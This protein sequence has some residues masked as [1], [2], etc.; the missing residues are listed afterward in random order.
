MKKIIRF[1]TDNLLFI[2]VIFLLAFIP[3]YPKLPLLDITNTWVYVRVEDFVVLSTLLIWSVYLFKQKVTLKTPLT[4][5]I[6][7]FWFIGAIST[8]HGVVLI[9]P[10]LANVFPNVA[11]L[12][13]IRHIEYMSLF[14]IAFSAMRDR[15]SLMFVIWTIV[16]TLLVV[17]FYGFGQK[18]LG[19]PAFLTMNEE[20]AKGIPIQLSQLSRVPSTFAGH[21]DLAAYLVLVIPIVVS[22]FFGFKN[23]FAKLILLVSAVLGFGLLFMTV[24]RVSFFV[25]LVALFIVIY[26]QKKRLAVISI[27]VVLVIGLLFISFQPSLLERFGSTVKEVEVLVDAKTGAPVGHVSF[28]PLSYLKDKLIVWEKTRD[29]L[30]FEMILTEKRASSTGVLFNDLP[31]K[32]MPSHVP[33]MQARTVSTGESLP[34]GTGYINLHLSP[35]TRRLGN[36]YYEIESSKN[37][38]TAATVRVIPG[39]FLV[40]KAAAYDLSFTTR[41]QGEWPRAIKAFTNNFFFGSGYGSVSLAVD[42]N[43][44]RMLGETGLLGIGSFFL[45]FVFMGVFIKRILPTVESKL[46]RSFVIGFCAGIVGLFLNGILIDVFEASKIA[47]ILW[48]LIGI[49]VGLLYT[50]KASD[51]DINQETRKALA[52]TFAVLIYIG[53]GTIALFSP[54]LSNFFVGDDFTWLRWAAESKLNLSTITDYFL[55]SD[56]F[57]YRP[58]TKTYF[59]VMYSIFWLNP[60]VYHVV[61]VVLHFLAVVLFY[62]LALKVT[63]DKLVS[64]MS[65]FIF[66]IGSGYLE[67][68][69]WISVT[70]HLFSIVFILLSVLLY[71]AWIDTRRRVFY[72]LSLL[73]IVLGLLFYEMGIVAPL[74]IIAYLLVFK[75]EKIGLRPLLSIFKNLYN[76]LIFTPVVFYLLIRWISQSHWFNGDYSY[77][78]LKL[79]FN[80]VGNLLG[81]ILLTLFGP[82]TLPIYQTLR[83]TARENIFF[84]VPLIL[85]IGT[86]FYFAIRIIKQNL[87]TQERKILLFGILFF[88]ISLIPFLGLG[89]IAPRYSYLA[90]FGLILIFVLVIRKL[91]GYLLIYGRDIAVLGIIVVFSVFSLLHIIQAQQTNNDWNGAGDKT[92]N[93]L[94]SID[95]IYNNSWAD[96]VVN[97][98]FVDVPIKNGNAWVFPVGLNDAVWFAFKNENIHIRTNN[99]VEDALDFAEV[100]PLTWVLQFEG[101]GGLK[102]VIR[103]KKKYNNLYK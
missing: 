9:F 31:L 36:V 84:T 28:V 74:L 78:L 69:V 50:Y 8:M 10:T 16:V 21:Y 91:Y 17:T 82:I 41:F 2:L 24:S 77:D 49:T 64:G 59:L 92:Q 48:I 94:I 101:D 85:I 38:S 47:F 70:G 43:Y 37:A 18:Y 73:S 55:N 65:A 5:P 3:L 96:H 35:V 80:F 75:T 4:I 26:F 46:V 30:D 66:L 51:F 93:F 83:V 81:Y 25:L 87:V 63:R 100:T 102:E 14:F 76:L 11:L 88:I 39:E 86:A 13:Y 98:Y 19:F 54:I 34:Q 15:K 27:P 53:I 32:K 103:V 99:N 6:L 29:G 71:I 61:S 52:S 95:G 22:L 57:F 40:K 79:P 44:F 60:V 72:I 97:L 68:V 23:V 42:N 90:S 33:L 56:G 45:I 67:A 58:G 62:L 20:F 7:L 1:V 89:N 12:S